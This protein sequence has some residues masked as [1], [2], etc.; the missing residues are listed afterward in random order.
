[1][2]LDQFSCKHF[3]QQLVGLNFFKAA[4]LIIFM[5]KKTMKRLEIMENSS[6]IALQTH[7]NNWL[8]RGL[9]LTPHNLY[10]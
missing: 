4:V 10:K 9:E 5:D 2:H 3:S 7:S 6:V 1:M 8:G